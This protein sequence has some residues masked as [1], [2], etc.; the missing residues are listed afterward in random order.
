MSQDIDLK[1]EVLLYF[2]QDNV[3]IDLYRL[4]KKKYGIEKPE[5]QE[6]FLSLKALG[7][8]TRT[9]AH[10]TVGATFCVTKTGR[11]LVEYEYGITLPH[12]RAIGV[13]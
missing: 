6:V 9:N 3:P 2:R 8:I 10:G 11:D 4:M 13:R 12:P 5:V 7:Y 1:R